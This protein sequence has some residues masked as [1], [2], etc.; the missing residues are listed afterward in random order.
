MIKKFLATTFLL[1]FATVIFAQGN[2]N[3]VRAYG[4]STKKPGGYAAMGTVC[5]YNYAP[6]GPA[7][8]TYYYYN[9]DT[10]TKATVSFNYT[11]YA[12][13]PP[14]FANMKASDQ[15]ILQRQDMQIIKQLL[16][17]NNIPHP[18]GIGMTPIDVQSATNDPEDMANAAAATY[19]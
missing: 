3:I 19:H 8:I 5:F 7:V 17:K 15:V 12:S 18:A 6:N 10:K 2:K 9:L 13:A 16:D 14:V 4:I 11:G 1:A